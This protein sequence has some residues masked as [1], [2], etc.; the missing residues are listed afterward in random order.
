MAGRTSVYRYGRWQGRF[1]KRRGEG[2]QYPDRQL[3][4]A[5][6]T[7]LVYFLQPFMTMRTVNVYSHGQSLCQL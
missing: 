1:A 3:Y 4:A 5:V 2:V 6:R 7:I